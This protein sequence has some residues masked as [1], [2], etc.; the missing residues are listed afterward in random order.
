MTLALMN[1]MPNITFIPLLK[2]YEQFNIY[3]MITAAVRLPLL[4]LVTE[5]NHLKLALK[6]YWSF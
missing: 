2:L 6:L 1:K 5:S 3:C 4:V